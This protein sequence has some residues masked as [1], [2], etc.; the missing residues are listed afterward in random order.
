MNET[1]AHSIY[2][3]GFLNVKQVASA[4]VEALQKI[5]GYEAPEAAQKLQES[6]ASVVEKAGDLLASTADAADTKGTFTAAPS[7][8]GDAK[9]QAEERLREMLRQA[10]NEA[11]AANGHDTDEQKG[12][13]TGSE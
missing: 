12:E 2:Q 11:P 4:P 1:F 3:A 6:A 13:K 5:A 7:R 9:A 8:G 10:G